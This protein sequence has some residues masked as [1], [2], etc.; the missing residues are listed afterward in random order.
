MAAPVDWLRLATTGAD[1]PSQKRP[2]RSSA[3]RLGGSGRAKPE[4]GMLYGGTA[5]AFTA[6]PRDSIWREAAVS[7][8]M[9]DLCPPLIVQARL[10]L[11]KWP[12]TL[13][14][15]VAGPEQNDAPRS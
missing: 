12:A 15:A 10:A 4:L 14:L 8:S 13:V 5:T 11:I 2:P 6:I 3:S 1:W 7:P 9:R